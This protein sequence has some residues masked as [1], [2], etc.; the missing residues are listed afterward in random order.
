M[1]YDLMIYFILIISASLGEAVTWALYLGHGQ[2]VRA[3]S[4]HSER[5][6]AELRFNK[7]I[8]NY[9]NT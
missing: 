6:Y 4:G 1:S 5:R 9:G 3:S 7:S 8:T 2:H